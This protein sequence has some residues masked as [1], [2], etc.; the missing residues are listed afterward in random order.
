MAFDAEAAHCPLWIETQCQAL[1]RNPCTP[2]MP[3]SLHSASS[4]G[5]PTNNSYIR[6]E[7]HPNSRTSSSG[8]TTFP[9]DFDIFSALPLLPMYV[10]MRSEERRVG[11]ECR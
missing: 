5:G 10:I 1:R 9:L 4:S 7:S 11:K 3:L 8:L 6:S 2:L